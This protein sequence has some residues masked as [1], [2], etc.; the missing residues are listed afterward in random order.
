M[1]L[2]IMLISKKL[3]LN[4]L[5]GEDPKADYKYFQNKTTVNKLKH[6]T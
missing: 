5:D 2:L 6:R 1:F 4:G 3:L